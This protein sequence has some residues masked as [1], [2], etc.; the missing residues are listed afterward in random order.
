ML[1]ALAFVL[2]QGLLIS[3]ALAQATTT[4]PGTPAPAADTG[5]NPLW[6]LIIVVLIAAAV[7]YF[8]RRRST[9]ATTTSTTGAPTGT[10]VYDR[11]KP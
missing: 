10:R 3:S 8:M 9:T 7:W 6:L 4:A 1:H 2:T 11:D 5:F